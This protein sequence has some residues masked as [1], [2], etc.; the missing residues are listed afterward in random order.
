M[1]KI[2]RVVIALNKL[3]QEKFASFK[4]QKQGEI[5]DVK[6]GLNYLICS[7]LYSAAVA[8]KG[9]CKSLDLSI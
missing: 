2:N 5:H 9:T 4:K 8:S 7:G 6:L 1:S 3:I